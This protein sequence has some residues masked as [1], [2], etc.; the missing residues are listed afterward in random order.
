M[1]RSILRQLRQANGLP[2][3]TSE[4]ALKFIREQAIDLAVFDKTEVVDRVSKRLRRMVKEGF[5]RR[6][7]P[8]DTQSEGLWSLFSV[9]DSNQPEEQQ[10]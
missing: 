4:I 10:A 8:L 3:Y 9:S 2:V 6:H 1:T 7:H 5:V